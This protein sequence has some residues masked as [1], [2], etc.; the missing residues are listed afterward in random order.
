MSKKL[1]ISIAVID[2]NNFYN[3]LVKKWVRSFFQ[4]SMLYKDFQVN[5]TSATD[6]K[7]L[8]IAHD[9]FD[10]AFID[11][12]LSETFTAI[13]VIEEF[14]KYQ[15]SCKLIITSQSFTD[16]TAYYTIDKGADGFL[17]KGD[18]KLLQKKCDIISD[19]LAGKQKIAASK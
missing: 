3:K 19:I 14:K 5:I 2:D 17:F 7:K 8:D 16:I 4:H 10:V 11:Y 1:S 9:H 6:P 12:Y 18:E 13:P 15:P